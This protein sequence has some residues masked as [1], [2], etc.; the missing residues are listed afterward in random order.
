MSTGMPAN[1]P[2]R[3]L[4]TVNLPQGFDPAR[5][6]EALTRLISETHGAGWEIENLN[7][8]LSTATASRMVEISE[9]IDHGDDADEI[10]IK[11]SRNTKPGD[12]EKT[13]VKL[14]SQHD[15]Y[16]LTE[17]EP[18]LGYATLQKM[19]P[20]TVRA[21]G[22][23]AV[24]L[25]VKPWEVQIKPR[26]DG[27][28][29]LGLPKTYVPS[30]HDDKLQE[31]A[32][33][34]I[35]KLGWYVKTNAHALTADIVPSDPPTFP[36]AIKYPLS[37]I[38]RLNNTERLLLATSLGKTGDEPGDP[39]YLDFEASPHTQLNGTTGSGKTVTINSI[40]AGALAAGYELCLID[41][42]HKSVD[43]VWARD[44]VRPGF[45]GCDSLAASATVA[46]LVYEEGQRRAQVLKRHNVTKIQELP[47][48]IRPKPILVVMDELSGLFQPDDI[49]KGVPKDHPFVVSAMQAN[50]TRAILMG[51]TLK[52]AAEMRFVGIR[53][54]LSTQVANATTGI[55]PKLRSLLSNKLLQGVNP[56]KATRQQVFN[57]PTMVPEVP[58]NIRADAS[59]SKGVGV[60]EME[61]ADPVVYKS[62]YAS[63][64]EYR[65][66]LEQL[67]V[68]T[69]NTPAPSAADIARIAMPE[70][71]GDAGEPASRMRPEY[72]G[73]GRDEKQQ[74]RSDGLSGAAA[75][76]H[77][78]R[79]QAAGGRSTV[80]EDF[81]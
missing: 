21:R 22:A 72:G 54:L 24:A 32:E 69:T 34:V 77:D 35:G 76:A 66:A 20:N 16:Y 18:Y 33:S 58:S 41:V 12:G 26:R 6:E 31:V 43:F 40:I 52:L 7:L 65:A 45:W 57:D 67:R 36:K 28:F 71:G 2:R 60:L 81:S 61:G 19:A 51:A 56:T 55:P 48:A 73:F 13:A 70:E 23:A 80:P 78:L 64:Q 27:G 68:P 50:A 14:E 3:E 38:Q 46:T 59:V 44:F 49:P 75:A 30:K 47:A 62:F 11:L 29:T 5:H 9:V 4:I 42:E 15:G 1:R 10:Q 17:F 53:L 79:V 63:T 74:R 37:Q 25:G 8:A 39:L